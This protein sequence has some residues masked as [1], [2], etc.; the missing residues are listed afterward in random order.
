MPQFP[1]NYSAVVPTEAWVVNLVSTTD[2]QQA[3]KTTKLRIKDSR[4]LIWGLYSL[5]Y[6]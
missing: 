3:F 5:G 1:K 6:N 4:V 2:A